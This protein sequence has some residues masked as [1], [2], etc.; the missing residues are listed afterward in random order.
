MGNTV[1]KNDGYNPIDQTLTVN[2]FKTY[3]CKMTDYLNFET[4]QVEGKLFEKNFNSEEGMYSM[5]LKEKVR[6]S[7]GID[8]GSYCR[9]SGK[10]K[11]KYRVAVETPKS[12]LYF[13]IDGDDENQMMERF[14]T[15]SSLMEKILHIKIEESDLESKEDKKV[16]IKEDEEGDL[17]MDI[18][19][20]EKLEIK[21]VEKVEIESNNDDNYILNEQLETNEENDFF[22]KGKERK[23]NQLLSTDFDKN[24][25]TTSSLIKNFNKQG[26]S[27]RIWNSKR[28]SLIPGTH[29]A[30]ERVG[31][32]I[33]GVM[34]VCHHFIYINPNEIYHLTGDSKSLATVQKLESV[35][36][37]EE[38][39]K[40]EG[41]V[42]IFEHMNKLPVTLMKQLCE[43]LYKSDK[44]TAGI[45]HVKDMNCEHFANF[46]CTG[47]FDAAQYEK[48]RNEFIEF[49]LVNGGSWFLKSILGIL[50]FILEHSL[51]ISEILISLGLGNISF[52]GSM[53]MLDQVIQ[54][55]TSCVF[56]IG[57][58]I[59]NYFKYGE[60]LG[61]L[62]QEITPN[63][64]TGIVVGIVFGVIQLIFALAIPGP[65]GLG[66]GFAFGLL[67]SILY[68]GVN[69]VVKFMFRRWNIGAN[70]NNINSFVK[71][72]QTSKK[73]KYM[74]DVEEPALLI[75]DYCNVDFK[76]CVQMKM[77]RQ[78]RKSYI[79]LSRS[80]TD[81]NEYIE[82]K[83][84]YTIPKILIFMPN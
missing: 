50:T 31:S 34:N 58:L 66:I 77:I 57:K 18:G 9:L 35:E 29:F 13:V 56:S 60:E 38:M 82:C 76:I 67:G 51:K 42:W 74:K 47:I 72:F 83:S 55:I 1:L 16:E 41:T 81:D 10:Y 8:F 40:G 71:E 52:L 17:D 63:I 30:I 14:T 80:D 32:N 59:R 11:T 64:V 2:D 53:F 12:E 7:T 61:V 69:L 27:K 78:F 19:L 22:Q 36:D 70:W 24:N 26:R 45:F 84:R 62:F 4:V 44:N 5:F 21:E 39:L 49:L 15:I 46:I 54:T 33:I 79:L 6:D 68:P 73:E 25:Q 48:K 65:V 20:K 28:D 75:T 37:L 3:K 43:N 23:F